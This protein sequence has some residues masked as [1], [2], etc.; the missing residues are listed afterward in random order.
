[1]IL[2]LLLP[3]SEYAWRSRW[4]RW[5]WSMETNLI[6]QFTG[7]T[8]CISFTRYMH[9]LRP[10]I[11]ITCSN[12]DWHFWHTDVSVS[13]GMYHIAGPNTSHKSLGGIFSTTDMT[14]VYYVGAS[15]GLLYTL[16]HSSNIPIIPV[17]FFCFFFRKPAYLFVHKHGN[18]TPHIL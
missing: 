10:W 16:Q 14:K 8:M 5:W 15:C 3:T 2:Q 9:L 7:M 4:S 17:F 11:I 13:T 1:M 18:Y 6:N 12:V